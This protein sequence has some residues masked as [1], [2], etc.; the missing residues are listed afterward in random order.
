[1]KR[2]M[3]LI[4]QGNLM[5]DFT[6]YFDQLSDLNNTMYGNQIDIDLK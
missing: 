3:G 6:D 4:S 2:D 1:M 5:I